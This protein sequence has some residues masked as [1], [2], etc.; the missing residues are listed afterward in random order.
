[1]SCPPVLRTSGFPRYLPSISREPRRRRTHA[2]TSK[3]QDAALWTRRGSAVAPSDCAPTPRPPLQGRVTLC[4]PFGSPQVCGP[5]GRIP[6]T[7]T[8]SSERL[9]HGFSPRFCRR[10]PKAREASKGGA[11]QAAPVGRGGRGMW[12]PGSQV[13]RPSGSL[14]AGM[15][16]VRPCSRH[17]L[18]P[19]PPCPT[20]RGMLHTL[21]FFPTAGEAQLPSLIRRCTSCASPAVGTRN[22]TCAVW[23]IARRVSVTDDTC[24][25]RGTCGC[26]RAGDVKSPNAALTFKVSCQ[27]F[28]E[29]FR[30]TSQR[31]MMKPE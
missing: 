13:S 19:R 5:C 9:G 3:A 4:R 23:L 30:E 7:L 14:A 8:R 27:G 12:V 1:M 21:H 6:P 24:V 17:R 15:K 10:A 31:V 18:A 2:A 20:T 26:A 28:A 29:I 11:R 16:S 25:R 22:A